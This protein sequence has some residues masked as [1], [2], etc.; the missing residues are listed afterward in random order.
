M[1]NTL[2][3]VNSPTRITNYHVDINGEKSLI[4]QIGLILDEY[5]IIAKKTDNII[6]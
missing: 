6:A 4:N 1:K 5:L 3:K 2:K